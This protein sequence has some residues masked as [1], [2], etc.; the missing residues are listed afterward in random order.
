M[1]I[2]GK[3]PH[4]PLPKLAQSVMPQKATL[5]KSPAK[6]IITV[7]FI[8]AAVPAKSTIMKKNAPA[9]TAMR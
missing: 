6:E 4:T 2:P 9:K 7:M 8:P 1:G 3:R 5:L